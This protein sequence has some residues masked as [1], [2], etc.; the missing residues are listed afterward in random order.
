MHKIPIDVE[1]DI[2]GHYRKEIP[3]NP[4]FLRDR[5]VSLAARLLQPEGITVRG[6]LDIDGANGKPSNPNKQ[7]VVKS[8]ETV[9]LGPWR[10]SSGDNVIVL[11]GQTEPM[12]A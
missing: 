10:L 5:T 8:G 2:E 4:P 7:F 9:E 11:T 12:R 3:L 6:D 1:T